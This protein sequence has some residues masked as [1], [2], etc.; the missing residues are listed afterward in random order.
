MEL[1]CHQRLLMIASLRL[2][3]QYG[4]SYSKMTTCGDVKIRIDVEEGMQ[5]LLIE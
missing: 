2:C 3:R 1:I 5:R 4:S